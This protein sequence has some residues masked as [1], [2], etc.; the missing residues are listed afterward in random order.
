MTLK[1]SQENAKLTVIRCTV[2]RIVFINVC[3]ASGSLRVVARQTVLKTGM[4]LCVI[5]RTLEISRGDGISK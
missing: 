4:E 5:R 3:N 2:L 1:N